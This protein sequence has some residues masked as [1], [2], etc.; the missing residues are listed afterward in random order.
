ME[1]LSV[2]EKIMCEK[3]VKESLIWLENADLNA[4]T[5]YY[6]NYLSDYIW[7][8]I[9]TSEFSEDFIKHC[10][11]VAIEIYKQSFKILHEEIY[12]L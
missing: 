12:S 10:I 2:K 1:K 6:E 7:N 3:T 9:S 8:H 4:K 11:H 5:D